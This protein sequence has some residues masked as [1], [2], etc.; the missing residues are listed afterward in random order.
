MKFDSDAEYFNPRHTLECGQVF[1]FTPYADGYRVC[2]ADKICY[3][4][5]DGAKTIVES[6]DCDYFYRYFDL[7]RN[8]REIAEKAQSFNIPLLSKSAQNCKGLRILN[9]DREEMIY[10]FIISQNNNIPRI[11]GIIEKICLALGEKKKSPWG[12]YYSFPTSGQLAAADREIFKNAGAG[13]RDVY[14]DET[15]KKIAAEGISGLENLNAENLKK[16]LL[17]YKGIGPKVA[18]CIALFGFGKTDS[19]PVDV[20]IEKVYKEDF[21]GTERDR[22]KIAQYFLELFGQYS[23]YIQQ[24]LFY[25]KR[26]NL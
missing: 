8:Y 17:T 12:E 16:K 24:Y 5:S 10:S 23:G 18:D 15:S 21:G 11:K 4:H 3:V 13:Y 22:N 9:A 14:L 26:L 1:R 19:F 2:S 7:D 20:W 25:G 6:D